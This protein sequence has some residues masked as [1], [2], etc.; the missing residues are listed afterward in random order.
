MLAGCRVDTRVEI[1]VGDGGGGTVR[2]VVALDAEALDR[3]GGLDAA[4]SQVPVDD[5]RAAGWEVGPWAERPGGGAEIAFAHGFRDQGELAARIVD[6]V[7]PNGVLRDPALRRERG[8]FRERDELTL[9]VDLR[10]PTTGIGSDTDLQARLRLAGVDPAA[11][12]AR[13]TEELRRA[14]RVEIVVHLPGGAHRRFHPPSGELTTVTASHAA[15]NWG[16]VVKLAVAALLASVGGLLFVAAAVSARR[17]RRRRAARRR[18]DGVA[19][20]RAPLS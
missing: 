17:S 16:A 18:R 4:R 20:D 14:L 7:G 3:L 1:T 11:L 8:W 12:D 6:L 19:L 13:L 5:L 9:L 2:T 15:R 10:A